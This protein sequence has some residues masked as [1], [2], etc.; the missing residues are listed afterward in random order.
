MIDKHNV[1]KRTA[2]LMLEWISQVMK[3]SADGNGIISYDFGTDSSFAFSAELLAEFDVLKE[4]KRFEYSF[5]GADAQLQNSYDVYLLFS[6]IF[7]R[8][9]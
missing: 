6:L 7:T 1:R 2:Q 4:K 9:F 3:S 8:I 5:T